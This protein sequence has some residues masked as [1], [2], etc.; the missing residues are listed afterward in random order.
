MALVTAAIT[1][2]GA[3]VLTLTGDSTVLMLSGNWSGD[4]LVEIGPD[5]TNYATATQAV[6]VRPK[7]GL[8]VGLNNVKSGWRVRVTLSHNNESQGKVPSVYAAVE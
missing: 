7:V 3:T 4:V 5:G 6:G 2:V 1:A 8:I